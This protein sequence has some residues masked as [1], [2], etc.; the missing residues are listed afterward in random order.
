MS[1]AVSLCI[2]RIELNYVYTVEA[3]NQTGEHR[4]CI[5]LGMFDFILFGCGELLYCV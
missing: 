5:I 4:N 2:I 3:E 1:V